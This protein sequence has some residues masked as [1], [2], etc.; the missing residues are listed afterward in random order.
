[1][2]TW[3]RPLNKKTVRLYFLIFIRLNFC[4]ILIIFLLK[5]KIIVINIVLLIYYFL[6]ILTIHLLYFT[7]TL[8]SCTFYK[9]IVFPFKFILIWT[10]IFVSLIFNLSIA[11]ITFFCKIRCF[12]IQ[13]LKFISLILG[14]VESACWHKCLSQR[15][16][17]SYSI[18]SWYTCSDV[19]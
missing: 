4:G 9:S 1:L 15:V 7:S 14:Q 2:W 12:W 3:H 6:T 13:L 19:S 16:G 17:F 8:I 18:G 10:L 5:D 11:S